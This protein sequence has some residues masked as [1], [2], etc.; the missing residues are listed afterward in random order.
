MLK[1]YTAATALLVR[2]PQYPNRSTPQ[3]LIGPRRAVAA[4]CYSVLELDI[5]LVC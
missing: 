5:E 3:P 2:F 1:P 4:A